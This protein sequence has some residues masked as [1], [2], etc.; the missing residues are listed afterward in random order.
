LQKQEHNW[1]NLCTESDYF[2]GKF[3][4]ISMQPKVL[5]QS[6]K[7]LQILKTGETSTTENNWLM[8]DLMKRVGLLVDFDGETL[9]GSSKNDLMRR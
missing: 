9:I 1:L 5:L 3:H 8:F 2:L 4:Q 6:S 7:T